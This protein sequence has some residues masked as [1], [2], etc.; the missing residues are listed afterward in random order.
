M[1]SAS[2]LTIP[3]AKVSVGA[4]RL[5]PLSVIRTTLKPPAA[6]PHAKRIFVL[7]ALQQPEL[8]TMCAHTMLNETAPLIN[9]EPLSPLQLP[10]RSLPRPR[11][12]AP[13]STAV[14]LKSNG[15]APP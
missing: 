8:P 2:V 10:E 5:R 14:T 7:P 6:D 15:V 3:T 4:R 11:E 12:A 9:T 1:A 13:P